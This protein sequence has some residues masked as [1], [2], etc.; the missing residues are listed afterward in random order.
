M[1]AAS[2]YYLIF[3][4]S[5][6]LVAQTFQQY[7]FLF[8]PLSSL[9][10]LEATIMA[11]Q[12]P[13]NHVR[14]YLIY[15]S[16]FLMI[17]AFILMCFHFFEQNKALSIVAL[18]FFIFFC[19]LEISY[20][21]VHIF[22]VMNSWGKEFNESPVE[23]RASLILKFQYFNQIVRAIYFPLLFSLFLASICLFVLSLRSKM[24]F[25][26]VAMAISSIQQLS[27]LAGYTS[28]DFL[29]VFTGVSYCVL[30][31]MIFTL[32]IY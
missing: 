6:Y 22:Q 13:L 20:R 18:V 24:W 7:L 19:T 25:W 14:H 32:L 17:P 26:S 2:R 23:M 29:D 31:V 16:M 15:F 30:V 4:F 8:G 3:A 1:N 27:R 5:F 21:S 28:L 11:G 12:H 9:D 10:S